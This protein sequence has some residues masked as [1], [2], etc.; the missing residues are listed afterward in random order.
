VLSPISFC[1][2][3]DY[4]PS[5]TGSINICDTKGLKPWS[6]ADSQ[7]RSDLL[8][9]FDGPLSAPG[10]KPDVG[11]FKE[12]LLSRI[13]GQS[14]K[15]SLAGS[16]SGSQNRS[17]ESDKL[18]WQLVCKMMESVSSDENFGIDFENSVAELLLEG[19]SSNLLSPVSPSPQIPTVTGSASI[20][21]F[22]PIAPMTSALT[23]ASSP[24]LPA[25][26]LYSKI[27]DL[28]ARGNRQE[29]AQLAAKHSDWGLA[30]II[31]SVCGTS[32]YQSLAKEY[33]AAHFTQGTPLHL[34]SLVFSNQ[35]SEF[36]HHGGRQ[37]FPGVVDGQGNTSSRHGSPVP[38]GGKHR[39]HSSSGVHSNSLTYNWRRNLC[40][41]L[42]NKG[43]D[44]QQLA[45]L[46]GSRVL[47]DKRDFAAAHA[48][49]LCAGK[50]PCRPPPK[51]AVNAGPA[52]NVATL[53]SYSIIGVDTR[54][55]RFAL[56]SDCISMEAFR[57]TEILEW[58]ILRWK[59]NKSSGLKLTETI[60]NVAASSVSGLG[61]SIS[62][63]F[64]FGS[65]SSSSN[66]ASNAPTKER[67]PSENSGTLK[68]SS[69][70]NPNVYTLRN[71]DIFEMQVALTYKK[72]RFAQ[73][74]ADMGLLQSAANY[75]DETER[76]IRQ[77]NSELPGI[78]MSRLHHTH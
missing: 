75:I 65:G 66:A 36:L 12:F 69:A 11:V 50:L 51:R 58:I 40:A 21:S 41:I 42:S 18:L 15:A 8:L 10:R 26:A 64:S 19:T 27:E 3:I 23:M 59:H 70:P 67:R 2:T 4:F 25:Q 78:L 39:R 38:S 60:T 53:D 14:A 49:F 5:K 47:H 61:K 28:L 71:E 48:I 68:S 55:N 13:E 9:L 76:L 46:L 77:L 44:W 35:A 24:M 62:G 54:H 6:L 31:G 16:G 7:M 63:L 22:T 34:L 57:V 29:A 20:Q 52:G 37:L 45:T 30:L 74:L 32:I 56:L 73:M 72:F 17:S 33:A 43:S 1:R